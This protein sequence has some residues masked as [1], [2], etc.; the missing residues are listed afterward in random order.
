MRRPVEPVST[1]TPLIVAQLEV[2]GAQRVTLVYT[3]LTRPV[4]PPPAVIATELFT[5]VGGVEGGVI[6]LEPELAALPPH[7]ARQSRKVQSNASNG[8]LAEKIPFLLD[9]I[10]GHSLWNHL[11]NIGAAEK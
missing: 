10:S 5:P 1:R 7:P 4:G 6:G 8:K 2:P 11:R 3:P 9:R